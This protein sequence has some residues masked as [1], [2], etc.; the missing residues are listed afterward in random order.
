MTLSVPLKRVVWEILPEQRPGMTYEQILMRLEE[1]GRETS[2]KTLQVNLCILRN[3]NSLR[4][5]GKK[6][7][8]YWRGPLETPMAVYYRSGPRP[9]WTYPDR[10]LLAECRE[11]RR[12]IVE[13]MRR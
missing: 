1:I 12:E 2:S 8:R 11:G 3:A 5:D 4:D 10:D 9:A 13:A 6:P 7:R